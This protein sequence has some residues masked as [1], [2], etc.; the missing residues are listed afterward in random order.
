MLLPFGLPCLPSFQAYQSL[1]TTVPMIMP[2]NCADT[3]TLKKAGAQ[4]NGV[5]FVELYNGKDVTPKNKDVT[6]YTK[7]MKKYAKGVVDTDFSRA[8]F[9][10]IMNIRALLGSMDPRR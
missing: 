1:G 10:S 9:G 7:E 6:V 2:D 3:V 5:Y 4:A 8:G